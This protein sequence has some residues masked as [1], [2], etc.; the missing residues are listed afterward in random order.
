M[1][2]TFIRLS[3][4]VS[5][6]FLFTGINFG[7][8]KNN[9]DKDS[10]S[11][12][13]K[14]KTSTVTYLSGTDTVSAYLA[15]PVGKEKS[16]AL[17]LVHEWWGLTPW[18]KENADNFAKHGIAALAIDL[19]RGKV[20]SNYKEAAELSSTLPKARAITDLKSAFQYLY[21]MPQINKSK[22]G[23][24]GWCFGGGYSFQAA[25]NIPKL[26]ACVVCYGSLNYSGNSLKEIHCPI[27]CV[28]GDSDKVFPPK[29]VNDFDKDAKENFLKV[30]VRFYSGGQHAFMNQYNKTGYNKADAKEAWDDIYSFLDK[31]LIR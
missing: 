22:I 29:V 13:F 11:G 27:L 2:N 28:F 24:I 15:V 7:Y 30:K 6:S 12:K 21:I 18:M 31:N 8:Q 16:P 17:I 20:T 25:L 14:I 4:I 19:Y 26:K 5:L 23:S 1:K 9:V 10:S 3:F